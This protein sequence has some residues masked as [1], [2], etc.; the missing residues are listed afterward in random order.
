MHGDPVITG[1][2]ENDTNFPSYLPESDLLL[3]RAKFSKCFAR[4]DTALY[5]KA[6]IFVLK[7]KYTI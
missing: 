4:V 2:G 6:L 1:L 7:T 5:F 3:S